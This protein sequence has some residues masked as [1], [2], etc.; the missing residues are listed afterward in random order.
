MKKSLKI[1]AF[2]AFCSLLPTAAFAEATPIATYEQ[3]SNVATNGGEAVLQNDIIMT[4]D[5]IARKDLIIDLNGHTLT[6]STANKTIGTIANLTIKDSSPNKTGK[7]RTDSN[8]LTYALRCGYSNRSGNCFIESVAIEANLL[9]AI[10][11]GD[12]VMNGGSL[13]ADYF[14]IAGVSNANVV[15]ND[16]TIEAND[17]PTIKLQGE[18]T[19]FEMNGGKIIH[20]GEGNA[21]VL[22]DGSTGIIN[23]GTIEAMYQVP[24]DNDGGTAVTLFNE[25]SLTLKNGT[26]KSYSHT[27]ATNG[28]VESGPQDGRNSKLYIYGGTLTSTIGDALYL[29]SPG[30]I[31]EI[32]GGNFT[33]GASAL[34]IRAGSLQ[35]KDGTFRSTASEYSVSANY[36]GS[37]T[38]GA[39]AA[40]A[41]HRTKQT[42]AFEICGGNFYGQVA[43]SEANAEGNPQE[44]INQIGVVINRTCSEPIFESESDQTVISEDIA[45]FIEGGTFSDDIPEEYVAENAGKKDGTGKIA[46]Y[47]YHK[48]AIAE[49]ENGLITTNAKKAL[50][51]DN[52]NI[53]SKPNTGYIIKSL[54][55]T[56]DRT[57]EKITI[58]DPRS[59]TM[60]DDNV[61]VMAIFESIN[62][63]TD[64]NINTSIQIFIASFAFLGLAFYIKKH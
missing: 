20:N 63:A 4:G 15:L 44:A 2:V 50:Y 22:D 52:I 56:N 28:T 13:K 6:N 23:N 32:Y 7:Y 57:E 39:A 24:N 30:G 45:N 12:F 61:T 18:N 31:T 29:P 16:S 27:I 41:Q 46:V 14:A 8:N 59:F 38:R 9:G 11:Y 48:I 19:K 3:L 53:T 64:D 21:L 49:S 26:L 17:N 5:V 54:I 43:F 40:V 47:T 36:T 1:F 55:L 35:I 51:G 10:V 33:G 25:A 42:I 37:T 60:P 34:E 62:P 58:N